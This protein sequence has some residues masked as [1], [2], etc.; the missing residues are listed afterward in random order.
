MQPGLNLTVPSQDQKLVVLRRQQVRVT[1]ECVGA[2]LQS[3]ASAT[4]WTD[5]FV[6]QIWERE[7]GR[8][9]IDDP[10]RKNIINVDH[11]PATERSLADIEGWPRGFEMVIRVFHHE[12]Q[13][14]YSV[15]AE[16]LVCANCGQ[17][18]KRNKLE[19]PGVEL[20]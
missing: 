14:E 11:W 7:S 10:D 3:G 15:R 5:A 2:L 17:E 12:L 16:R 8:L 20:D 13:A 19:V 4:R 9:S 6:G 18:L 1:F